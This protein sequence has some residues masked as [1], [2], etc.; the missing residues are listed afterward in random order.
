MT[1]ITELAFTILKAG[2]AFGALIGLSAAFSYYYG[3]SKGGK[4]HD[5]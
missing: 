5:N 2:V 4:S 3:F 1:G